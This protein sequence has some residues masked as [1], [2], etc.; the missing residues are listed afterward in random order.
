MGSSGKARQRTRRRSP[1]AP[2]NANAPVPPHFTD[3]DAR[4]ELWG[5]LR[6]GSRN[7]AGVTWHLAVS[8]HVLVM[9]RAGIL[10]FTTLVPEG[11]EDLDCR[12]TTGDETLVQVK[13]VSAGAGQLG[14]SRIR[15][16]ILHAMRVTTGPIVIVTDG[17]VGSGL[18]FTGWDEP[19]AAQ[20]ERCVALA[21]ALVAKGLTKADA[22]SVLGRV[23]LVSLPWN[24]REQT[25]A[26]LCDTQGVHPSVASFTVGELYEAFGEASADQRHL[27][28][29]R[30]RTL[31]LS[32]VDTV[33]H[34]V[35]SAVDVSGLDAAVSAGVCRPADYSA[36]GVASASR[37]YLGVDGA[38]IHIAQGLDVI[39]AD[40][41][42]QITQ[43]AQNSEYTVIVGPSGSG[44]SVLLWH[45]K[46]T[47]TPVF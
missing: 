18:Q 6:H 17:S 37:F 2:R 29:N 43:A 40:E 21:D 45:A 27:D 33:L 11:F 30:A 25:E 39:R 16:A 5:K 7:V 9:S 24:L 31:T 46:R 3:S 12:T 35:Q 26:L 34:R 41:M 47:L 38:P 14:T 22:T 36:T 8:V 1:I 44:K 32:D 13:E 10:P 28:L 42:D 15:D 4:E 20:P 19:L 23:H